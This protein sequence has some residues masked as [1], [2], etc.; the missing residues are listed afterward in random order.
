MSHTSQV[1]KNSVKI[2]YEDRSGTNTSVKHM[3]THISVF[4]T[5]IRKSK[6]K[7]LTKEGLVYTS[8]TAKSLG[9]PETK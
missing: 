5:V 4:K 9:N 3:N 6:S 2:V 1:G 7:V 8:D